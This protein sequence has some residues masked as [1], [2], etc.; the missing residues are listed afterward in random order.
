[1]EDGGWR[2]AIGKTKTFNI[3]RPKLATNHEIHQ[4]H[5]KRPARKS[6]SL[7]TDETRIGKSF[8][9]HARFELLNRSSRR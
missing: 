4:T 3:E 7:A 5:E 1:M 6:R 2:M 9:A 8:D